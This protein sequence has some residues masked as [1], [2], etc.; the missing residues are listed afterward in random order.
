MPVIALGFLQRALQWMLVLLGK[1]H[2]LRHFGLSNFVCEDTTHADALLV[3][4][5]HHT[6]CLFSVHLKKCLQHMNDKFHRGVI[7]IE[8]QHF[9]LAGLFRLWARACGKANART[10]AAIIIFIVTAIIG[11][12][13]YA[14]RIL[15]LHKTEIGYRGASPQEGIMR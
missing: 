10:S 12:E 9:I 1:I 3:D 2:H 15:K 8:Q 6:R 5:Q 4:M 13:G 14:Q 11:A 7:V